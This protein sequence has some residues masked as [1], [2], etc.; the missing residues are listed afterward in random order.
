MLDFETKSNFLDIFLKKVFKSL[1]VLSKKPFFIILK[2][3]LSPFL[4]AFAVGFGGISLVQPNNFSF[5]KRKKASNMRFTARHPADAL[6]LNPNLFF[7][8][9]E[10]KIIGGSGLYL[11]SREIERGELKEIHPKL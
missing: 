10:G 2:I 6:A 4:R 5:Q 8:L 3:S 7:P 1:T 11:V 9:L